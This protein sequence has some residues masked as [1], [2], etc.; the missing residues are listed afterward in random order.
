MRHF[1]VAWLGKIVYT[2]KAGPPHLALLEAPFAHACVHC[3]QPQGPEGQPGIA[4]AQA[5]TRLN[6]ETL[7]RAPDGEDDGVAGA[8]LEH[9]D[10]RLTAG[11]PEAGGQ[12]VLADER[13]LEVARQ[14]HAVRLDACVQ[15]QRSMITT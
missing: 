8:G 2:A 9:V 11:D 12:D 14:G 3:S 1:T 13:E 5:P 7:G 6:Q 15:V 4:V 10:A